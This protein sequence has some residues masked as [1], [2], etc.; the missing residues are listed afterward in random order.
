VASDGWKLLPE[1][2]FAQDSGL[3]RH[4]AGRP[5]PVLSLDDVSYASAAM[6]YP[7]HRHHEP[8]SRL[9]E[10]I[11]EARARLAAPTAPVAPV[12]D[13]LLDEDFESLRWFPLPSEALAELAG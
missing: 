7:A 1:Y 5:E 4:A 13:P 8:E 2:E 3:W 6:T 10:Y 9:A 12:A 11:A